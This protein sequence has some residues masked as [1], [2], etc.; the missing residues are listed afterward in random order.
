MVADLFI[1]QEARLLEDFQ[2][3]FQVVVQVID[4]TVTHIA[5]ETHI[6][7]TGEEDTGKKRGW[8]YPNLFN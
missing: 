2:V 8:E 5:I 6:H 1:Q 4:L 7:T 3:V